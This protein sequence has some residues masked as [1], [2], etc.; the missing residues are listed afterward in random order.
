MLSS[1]TEACPLH[2]LVSDET[3]QMKAADEYTLYSVALHRSLQGHLQAACYL[4]MCVVRDPLA[5]GREVITLAQHTHK[6]TRICWEYILRAR[7]SLAQGHLC[8]F[9]QLAQPKQVSHH[10]GVLHHKAPPSHKPQALQVFCNLWEGGLW[11]G[12][13]HLLEQASDIMSED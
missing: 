11:G 13:C 8:L 3:L 10:C 6:I 12:E 7:G 5:S 2:C 4:S 1:N 9:L